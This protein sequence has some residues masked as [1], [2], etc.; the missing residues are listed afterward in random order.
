[1]LLFISNPI[2]SLPPVLSLLNEFSYFSGYKL[3]LHKSELF[4]L[5]N[6]ALTTDMHNFPFK[7]VKHQF[8]YLG[9]TITRKHKHLFK[10]N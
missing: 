1:L 3:N 5:N 8:T 10:E 9:I 2:S 6:I 4:L 7:I